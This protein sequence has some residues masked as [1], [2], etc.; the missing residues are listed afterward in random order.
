VCYDTDVLL[1]Q[2][3]IKVHHSM[4]DYGKHTLAMQGVRGMR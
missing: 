1:I 2:G 4:F 3:Q